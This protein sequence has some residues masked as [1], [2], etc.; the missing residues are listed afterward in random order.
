M[1]HQRHGMSHT[2]TYNS[3]QAM[4]ERCTNKKSIGYARYGGRGIKVCDRWRESFAHFLED[5]GERPF[6]KAEIDREDNDGN[7]EPGNCVWRSRIENSNN[8]S[9]CRMIS[10][11]GTTQ[12]ITMWERELGFPPRA[13]YNRLRRGWGVDRALSTPIATTCKTH[14]NESSC[15]VDDTH[16]DAE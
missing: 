14:L 7:Y 13:I 16:N 5:M 1:K 8:R 12:S 9:T 11:Q 2:P 3:W 4:I 10:H 15:M 6:L